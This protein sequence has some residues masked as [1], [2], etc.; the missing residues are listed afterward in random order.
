VSTSRSKPQGSYLVVGGLGALGLRYARWLAAQGASHIVLT[1][2]TGLPDRGTWNS[3]DLDA[4]LRERI[5]GI[6]A[7]EE[8]GAS[9]DVARV[10]A[11]D[12]ASMQAL[13]DG[14]PNLRGVAFLAGLAIGKDIQDITIDDFQHVLWPK[15]YGGYVIDRVTRQR[16]LDFLVLFS[17]AASVWG[18]RGAAGYAGANQF[19]DAIAHARRAEGLPATVANW[20]RLSVRGMLGEDEE[21]LLAGIGIRPVDVDA[22]YDILDRLVQDDA[23]QAVIADVDWSRFLSHYHVRNRGRRFE[24]IGVDRKPPRETVTDRQ[25]SPRVI[26]NPG[27]GYSHRYEM[28]LTALCGLAA[29]ILGF[30]SPQ[31][32][33]CKVGFFE[34]GMDSLT[35][36][37]F[38]DR[39][40]QSFAIS[41]PTTALF[42]YTNLEEL[43]AHLAGGEQDRSDVA[44]AETQDGAPAVADDG[45]LGRIRQ[46]NDTEVDRLLAEWEQRSETTGGVSP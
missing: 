37:E 26:L 16:D 10:D 5:E 21:R 18:S 6:R 41:I 36:V 4:T 8:F 20:A 33:N 12:L 7:V 42:K 13:V 30:S 29:S 28:A 1:S 40:E 34:L 15:L 19:L 24:W 44:P 11:G 3:D 39:I 45:L 25:A 9:V 14:L 35:A 38:K 32:V 27:D 46:M 23:T 2:R 17:S 22:G 43:A 31:D